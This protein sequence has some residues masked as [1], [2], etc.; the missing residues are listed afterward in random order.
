M[1]LRELDQLL[2]KHIPSALA[3]HVELAAVRDGCLVL[4]ADGSAWSAQLRFKAPEILALLHADAEFAGIR[5]IRVRNVKKASARA[6]DPTRLSLG[7]SSAQALES[8]AACT[9]DAALRD[10]LLRLASRSRE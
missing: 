5:S 1:R 7:R 2:R 4:Q 10:V 6:E 3:E 8:Q 9:S